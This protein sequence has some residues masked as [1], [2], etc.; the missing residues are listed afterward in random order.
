M[1]N[2]NVLNSHHIIVLFFS[3]FFYFCQGCNK[4]EGKNN[5]ETLAIP[6][7]TAEAVTRKVV[8]T[9][10]QVG[11]L[12]AI[13]EVGIRSE[14][15]GSIVEILFDEGRAVERGALLVRLDSAKIQ[16][17]IEAL[18]A[19][20]S[21]LQVRL[22]N[23]GR[24]LERKRPLVNQELVSRIDFDDLQTEIQEI[25]AEIVWVRADL[26]HVKERLND[27]FIRA[28][29]DGV[30]GPREISV[31][32]YLKVGESVVEVIDLDPLEMTFQIPEK[33]SPRISINQEVLLTLSPFPDRRF[34]GEIFFISPVVDI[35]TRTFMVKARIENKEHVLKPGM[36]AHVELVTEIHD[37]ALTVPWESIIQ[38]ED[39]TYI[40]I[41]K[42]EVA[43]KFPIRLGKVTD[44]WAELLGGGLSPG[45]KVILEGKYAVKEGMKVSEN[46]TREAE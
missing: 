39:E 25:E 32:D 33:F 20:I 18:E 26:A 30:A 44:E 28:P 13:R 43:D 5:N 42:G 22:A 46:K 3:F 10:D 21:Q 37:N 11:T 27:T 17:E 38:T 15:E 1:L 41:V 16:A 29:F 7:I 24:T 35:N 40:Y 4:N 9:L 36:F 45:A 2:R 6:V 14:I 8:Y 19:R 31:G 12:E 23:R 34:T